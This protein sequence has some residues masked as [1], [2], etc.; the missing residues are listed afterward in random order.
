MSL[1]ARVR[2]WP[3]QRNARANFF[4]RAQERERERERE[5]KALREDPWLSRVNL[6]A[7][8]RRRLSRAIV[9]QRFGNDTF[10]RTTLER[11]KEPFCGPTPR[12]KAQASYSS[13]IKTRSRWSACARCYIAVTWRFTVSACALC[14]SQRSNFSRKGENLEIG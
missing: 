4:S 14:F 12:A 10:T 11:T 7:R 6:R 3:V 13:V 5:E 1:F 9:P 2:G 8:K